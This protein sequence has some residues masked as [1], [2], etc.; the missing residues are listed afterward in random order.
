MTTKMR[1]A[2][3][4]GIGQTE[5]SR[6]SGRS[7][8]K[9]AL[10]AITAAVADAGIP[11]QQV[12]G[13]VTYSM[14]SND[15]AKV[16]GA[17]DLEL[18][19][20]GQAGY[21]GG[22]AGQAVRDAA[23]A[24]GTGAASVVVVYRAFNERSGRR[25][26]QPGVSYAGPGLDAFN[27]PY[28]NAAPAQQV[29]L[30]VRRYMHEFGVTNSHF[31][32]LS[33]AFRKHAATNPAAY[34]YGLPITAEDHD[35]SRWIVEPV[36]RLL[37]CCLESDGGAALVITTVDRAR[38]LDQTAVCVVAAAQGASP[39]QP[40]KNYYR[41]Q[42]TSLVETR[43]V[44][45]KLW[46]SAGMTVDDVQAAIIYDNFLPLVLMQLE[47]LG[48]CRPGEAKDFVKDGA[49]EIGGRLPLNTNGGQVGE[50]YIHG[51]NGML[52]GVRQVRHTAVNQVE[53][54]EHILCTAGGAVPTS[55]VILGK[56]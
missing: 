18:S 27:V 48:F 25:L 30:G 3:I 12:D 5:F 23:W 41:D 13:L 14:D 2:A 43:V 11:L 37:D 36:L 7:E 20:F 52:E 28:G 51:M 38:D 50:A 44:G 32:P 40:N 45:R 10:E 16:A 34:F 49:V 9:L 6:R 22:G 56:L 1:D 19:Y 39:A 24:V 4:I 47:A 26:G 55:G 33:V 17:L 21:G 54:L 53:G 46:E 42:T 35:E 15:P 29:A 8:L 31:A